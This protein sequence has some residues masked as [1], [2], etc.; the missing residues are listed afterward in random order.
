[1]SA[2]HSLETDYHKNPTAI[3]YYGTKLHLVVNLQTNVKAL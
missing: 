3:F 2:D 1:M